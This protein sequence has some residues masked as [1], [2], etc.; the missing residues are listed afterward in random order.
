MAIVF[1]SDAGTISG[2]SVGGL[3]DGIVDAGTLATNSVDSA[4]LI[5]GAV[6]DSHIAALASSK[7]TGALPAISGASLTGITTGKVLQVA[8]ANLGGTGLETS[9]STFADMCTVTITPTSSSNKVLILASNAQSYSASNS[10]EGEVIV[11]SDKSSSNIGNC[12]TYENNNNNQYQGGGAI[13]IE[14][15]LSGWSSGSITY[16]LKGRSRN[17]VYIQLAAYGL[18]TLTVMEISA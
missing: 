1:N 5:D 17:N 14:Q 4:E 12:S 9:S 7:L 2:L 3:P 11:Y 8:S 15:S 6:D 18:A 16:R 10:P 13:S